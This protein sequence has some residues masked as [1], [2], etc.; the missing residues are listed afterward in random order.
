[1][2]KILVLDSGRVLEY[3]APY[4][5]LNNEKGHFK[6]LVSQL[7]DKIANSLYQMAK[8]AYEKIENT[9]L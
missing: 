6:R 7:G 5:L 9:N 2:D 1:M 8:N 4:L 3:D